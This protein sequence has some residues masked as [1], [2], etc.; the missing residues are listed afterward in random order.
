MV[1][2]SSYAHRVHRGLLVTELK[3]SGAC[4]TELIIPL[5]SFADDAAINHTE[6][7]DFHPPQQQRAL[8]ESLPS[9]ASLG[10]VK[11][12]EHCNVCARG[13]QGVCG[14]APQ[15]AV[16]RSE[17]PTSIT[18]PSHTAADTSHLFVAS[19]ATDL[20][21]SSESVGNDD[22]DAATSDPLAVAMLAYST[23]LAAGAAKLME[24]HISAWGVLWDQSAIEVEGDEQLA[25]Y[26]K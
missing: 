13:E 3:I 14:D 11:R 25:R 24:S 20:P 2:R 16:V 4:S 21:S 26:R 12:P 18:V 5:R 8:S 19:Y 10:K 15:V 23:A 9:V 1:E 7:F 17:I 6:D 22:G